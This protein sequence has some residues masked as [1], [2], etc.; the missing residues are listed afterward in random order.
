MTSVHMSFD[1]KVTGGGGG[2]S[3]AWASSPLS[4]DGQRK[5]LGPQSE[6]GLEAQH[7][8][9]DMGSDSWSPGSEGGELGARVPEAA[10]PSGLVVVPQPETVH[11]VPGGSQREG[12]LTFLTFDDSLARLLSFTSM[13][14]LT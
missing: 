5:S 14:S 3:E 2:Q 1:G 6:R 7:S 9:H 8:S 10:S 11:V 12:R 4:A 13:R